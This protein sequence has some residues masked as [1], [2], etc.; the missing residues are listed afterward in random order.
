M[1]FFSNA[2]SAPACAYA[3]GSVNLVISNCVVNLS[4][5]KRAVLREA[6]RALA[7]GGELHFSD[8][9]AD[10]RLPAAVRADALLVNECL[11]VRA[12]KHSG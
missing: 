10:R 6:H 11:G 5:D 2:P 7:Y 1:L 4:P 9:Y 12:L 8:V 3:D